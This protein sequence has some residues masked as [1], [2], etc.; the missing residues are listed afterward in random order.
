MYRL[1]LLRLL[2]KHIKEVDVINGAKPL[3]SQSEYTNLSISDGNVNLSN[4]RY[5][6][7]IR[8]SNLVSFIIR[9]QKY[10]PDRIP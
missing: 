10:I 8:A 2:Q 1:K 3:E 7:R 4:A 9:G 5:K 6:T